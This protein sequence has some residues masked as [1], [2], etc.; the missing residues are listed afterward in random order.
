[1]AP[2]MKFDVAGEVVDK[3]D[4]VSGQLTELAN[5]L[6]DEIREDTGKP[7]RALVKKLNQVGAIIYARGVSD[8]LGEGMQM[9]LFSAA[10]LAKASK[11]QKKAESEAEPEEQSEAA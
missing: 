8:A 6:D 11:K 7:V 9:E 4:E 5:L 3:A 2:L 1:M 10:A